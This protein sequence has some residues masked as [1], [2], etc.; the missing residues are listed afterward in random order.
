M[1]GNWSAV[2]KQNR[3]EFGEDYGG[4]VFIADPE[5]N[6]VVIKAGENI[7]EDLIC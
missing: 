5:V 2:Y 4:K 3:A 6:R 1:I 7:S